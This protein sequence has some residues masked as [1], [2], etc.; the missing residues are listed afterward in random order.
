V[1]PAFAEDA[2]VVDDEVERPELALAAVDRADDV[3]LSAHVALDE[4][5]APVGARLPGRALPG[6]CVAREPD[7]VSAFRAECQ[8]RLTA[9]TARCPRHHPR[10][11]G[12]PHGS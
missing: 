5:G 6:L 8:E 1:E 7:D 4:G 2:G 3:L 9:E 12:A 11:P 10:F